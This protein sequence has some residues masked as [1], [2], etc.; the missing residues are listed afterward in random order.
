M[1]TKNKYIDIYLSP[2]ELYNFDVFTSKLD[3]L[4]NSVRYS[5]L[6]RVCYD[7]EPTFKMLGNQLN[8]EVDNTSNKSF[9]FKQL[10][11]N[12]ILR[13]ENSI[14][15]YKYTGDDIIAIQLLVYNVTYTDNVIK[16]IGSKFNIK[17]LDI[18][19]DL[20]VTNKSL[21]NLGYNK[22]LPPSLNTEEY[23][24]KVQTLSSD[25]YIK[26]ILVKDNWVDFCSLIRSKNP[27]IVDYLND[28]LNI[29]IDSKHRYITILDKKYTNGK[30]Q[31]YISIYTLDGGHV[32]DVKD[33]R[34]SETSFSRNMGNITNMYTN[35]T[36]TKTLVNIKLEPLKLSK[37]SKS[38]VDLQISNPNIGTLDL[39]TY[40]D[41][42]ISKVYAIGFY[43]RQH[44]L[45]TFYINRETLDSSE[46]ILNCI[47]CM[48]TSKYTGYTFYVHNLGGYDIVFLL[49]TLISFNLKENMYKLNTTTRGN[50]I[51]S[52]SISKKINTKT[53]NIKIVDS[54]NI[55][56]H[57]LKDLCKTYKS[58]TV[59][60]IFPYEF[61][62]RHRLFYIGD[63]PSISMYKDLN[64]QTYYEIPRYDRSSLREIVKYIEINLNNLGVSINKLHYDTI[65]D[66]NW[67][68]EFET[69]KYLEKDLISLYEIINKFS[70]Y[71]YLKY[72]IQVSKSL[73]ISSLAMK[74]FLGKYYNFNI[75]L[76]V[77]RSLYNSIKQSYFG[78]I[79]EVYIP[80]NINN[81]R[82]Y[83]YDVN[84]LYPY[85]ALN[86]M[87]G[88]DCV[89][90]SD[91]NL[92]IKDIASLFGFYYCKVLTNNSYLGLL[93]LRTKNGL[94]MPNGE[95]EGWYFSEELK[96]AALNGY[97]IFVLKGYTFNKV[98]DIFNKYV[99]N[100]YRI[101]S[102]TKDIV[103]KSVTKSLLNNLLGRFGLDIDKPKT[104]L[105]DYAKYNELLQTKIINNVIQIE[106]KY[107]ITYTDKV[108]KLICDDA[109][110]DYK[111]TVLNS[112]KNKEES[113]QTFSDVSI[114]IAASV[115]SYARIFINKVKLDV[116]N[117][118]GNIY[119]T[120][121]DSV[122]TNI[123]LD[124][125]L[126][127]T[128]IGQ[129]KLEHIINKAYFISGKTYLIKDIFD[130]TLI[131]Y[132]GINNVKLNIDDFITL[133]K[134]GKVTAKR[135][136]TYRNFIE[137]YVNL[138]T[139]NI[140]LDGNSYTKRSKLYN[141]ELWVNTK[142]IDINKHKT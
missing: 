61:I 32:L 84:S 89:F 88:L 130:N 102:G 141:N 81:E 127:G 2:V 92:D 101:K 12:I 62:T 86:A 79:T 124:N 95:W 129:F 10:Y 46:L 18:S 78:G 57:S 26:S 121:T 67:S 63:K 64:K 69:I 49:K 54:Y 28:N 52:L 40:V 100:F 82:L 139:R 17:N 108:S 23:Y 125:K 140:L 1:T 85:A 33:N 39:E 15:H 110:V 118:G 112:L 68:S 19:N 99:D 4:N 9:V 76:I 97:K 103:E 48:L 31:H 83:Y 93:P 56:S 87:P 11:D 105:V 16:K 134:G 70:D 106:D 45:K 132:K 77:K 73:T 47:D 43:T 50:L 120:D 25:G 138:N 135:S 119:Y 109:N 36:I 3:I 123:P 107:L 20:V 66:H 111:N 115:T 55:L 133:Y 91:I 65:P 24:H 104:S 72:N 117:K 59:K 71:V 22:L 21:I 98:Y 128:D 7:V 29:F 13:L 14:L 74:I 96:F 113:E 90:E 42:E 114:A 126:V 80:T 30:L 8:F 122:V 53:Y 44:K 75:P 6:F 35:N 116:L 51:L 5:M 136:E 131:K 27:K 58:D 34:I 60:D 94:I 41:N 38:L 37:I 137:G 142:P